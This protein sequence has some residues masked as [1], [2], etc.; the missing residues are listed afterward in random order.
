MLG[1][2]V[3]GETVIQ[4]TNN[5]SGNGVGNDMSQA[6]TCLMI[7]EDTPDYLGQLNSTYTQKLVPL[8]FT[9]APSMI[10]IKW[11]ASTNPGI[12][13]G[14]C[15]GTLATN[16]INYGGGNNERCFINAGNVPVLGMELMQND[17]AISL[18]DY[19]TNSGSAT[20]K[21]T[22]L[23]VPVASGGL[24]RG[25]RLSAADVAASNDKS[26]NSPVPV[27]CL[28]SGGGDG[29]RCVAEFAVPAAIGGGASSNNS[30]IRLW[31]PYGGPTTD[32]SVSMNTAGGTAI[33][34]I[35]VQ[36]KIDSTGRANDIYRRVEAR[37]ELTDVYYPYPEFSLSLGGGSGA[38]L[39][40]NF[41]VTTSGS[42]TL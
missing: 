15:S 3:G 23:F 28:A 39:T 16:Q 10:T 33:E 29:W 5:A 19:A 14:S 26:L 1:R 21:A 37:V 22:L 7:A 42:G 20:N 34:F 9:S 31:L 30:F 35:G 2:T 32:F 18:A 36:A 12:G 13:F 27:N 6:Y 25:S 11:S 4:S 38:G 40:K 17:G 8:R 41:W 24:A